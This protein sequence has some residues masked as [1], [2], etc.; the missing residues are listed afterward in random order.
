M[1]GEVDA[2]RTMIV[3]GKEFALEPNGSRVV[4]LGRLDSNFSCDELRT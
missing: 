2:L 3:D 4:D 1:R